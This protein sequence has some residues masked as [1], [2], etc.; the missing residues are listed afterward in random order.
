MPRFREFPPIP[1][2]EGMAGMFAGS[3]DGRL[4]CM[5]GANFPDKKPWEGGRKVWHDRIFVLDEAG[6]AWRGIEQRMPSP[7]AYGVAVEYG[8]AL[9]LVG[10]NQESSFHPEVWHVSREGD[11]LRFKPYPALPFPLANMAGCRVG[12]LVLLAGGNRGFQ[13]PPLQTFLALDLEE[14]D[15]GWFELPSWPGPA[16]SQPV[17]GTHKGEFYLFSGENN[18]PDA[19]GAAFRNLLLDAYRFKP[20][21]KKEGW[22]GV[23]ES[24]PAMPKAASASANPV[25]VN[26]RGEFVF[27]GGVDHDLLAFKDPAKHPGIG[28]KVYGYASKK[29]V[30]S[31]LGSQEAFPSRVTLPAV[32][33]KGGW[34]YVSGEVK[35]GVRTPSIVNIEH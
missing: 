12:S 34:L 22:T 14:P 7:L 8:G 1:D 24:L 13:E 17:A 9:I 23:W 11:G 21:K 32:P 3:I 29:K 10:G 5:G 15:K 20:V 30:W 26:A 19:S 16:R 18:G 25:P 6:G 31:F 28:A 2:A 4:Y 27:W 35:P 33:W